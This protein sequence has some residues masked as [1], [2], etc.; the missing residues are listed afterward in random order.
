[1]KTAKTRGQKAFSGS[2]NPYKTKMMKQY[3]SNQIKGKKYD[4]HSMKGG[5]AQK[6][7]YKQSLEVGSSHYNEGIS[8]LNIS[9]GVDLDPRMI[10]TVNT[11]HVGVNNYINHSRK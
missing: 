4:N 3:S 1:M 9:S 6:Y 7:T 2:L 5:T 8:N 10:K 11:E